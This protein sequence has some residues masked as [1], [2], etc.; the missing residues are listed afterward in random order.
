MSLE[1]VT[2]PRSGTVSMLFLLE[3]ANITGKLNLDIITNRHE[4]T[5]F[6]NVDNY[7]I[8]ISRDPVDIISSIFVYEG[9]EYSE[10]RCNELIAY[11]EK[12]YTFFNKNDSE[13][14]IFVDFKDLIESPKEVLINILL[15]IGID[16]DI[17]VSIVNSEIFKNTYEDFLQSDKDTAIN[18]QHFPRKRDDEKIKK[19]RELIISNKKI[20]TLLLTIINTKQ[21]IEKTKHTK[22]KMSSL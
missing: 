2:P 9:V 13:Q 18:K 5:A 8:F 1:I 16:S 7:N 4:Y 6:D 12:F 17:S 19:L 14:N 20:N 10:S 21:I 3:S 22:V 11:I 15:T